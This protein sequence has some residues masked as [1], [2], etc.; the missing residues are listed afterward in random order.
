MLV[1]QTLFVVFKIDNVFVPVRMVLRVIQKNY[2][3]VVF[4]HPSHV[5][6]NL[7]AQVE[8]FAIPASVDH[9]VSQTKIVPSMKN[10]SIVDVFYN[11]HTIKNV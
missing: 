1:D 11:V 2:V 10:V 5:K 3:A 6:P 8:W 9:H 7:N 4:A